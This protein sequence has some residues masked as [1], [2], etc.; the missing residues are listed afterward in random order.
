MYA[1]GKDIEKKSGNDLNKTTKEKFQKL[2]DYIK[3]KYEDGES[4]H[5]H[6]KI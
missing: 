4:A 3:K 2:F 1:T 5:K 6:E